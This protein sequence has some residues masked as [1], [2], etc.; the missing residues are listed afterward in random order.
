VVPAPALPRPPRAAIA[1]YLRAVHAEADA[2]GYRFDAGKAGRARG[3]GPFLE[4]LGQLALEWA[5]LQAKRA[6]RDPARVT[7]PPAW[8]SS[9]P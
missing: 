4:T 2:R 3:R 7:R 9:R 5:H 8:V 6:R 1:A